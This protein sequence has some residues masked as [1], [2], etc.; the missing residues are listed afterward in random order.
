MISQSFLRTPFLSKL[1][2]TV[3]AVL[4]STTKTTPTKPNRQ[5]ITL[6]QNSVCF[7]NEFYWKAMDSIL[8]YLSLGGSYNIVVE[9]ILEEMISAFRII[10]GLW[11]SIAQIARYDQIKRTPIFSP[12]SNIFLRLNFCLYEAPLPGVAGQW[13]NTKT[14]TKPKNKRTV[15]K[16]EATTA[17]LTLH[18][19]CVSSQ[20][21]KGANTRTKFSFFCFV[22]RR[23]SSLH[24]F[25]KKQK[26][27]FLFDFLFE[28]RAVEC[29]QSVEFKYFWN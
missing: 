20:R 29:S 28:K 15:Q 3:S 7:S 18:R 23:V 1:L 21:D 2:Q 19:R 4:F 26:Y 16:G 12:K 27:F 22:L 17:V 8:R 13:K 11:V 9:R 25:R 14:K 10:Y 24:R 6:K 5:V